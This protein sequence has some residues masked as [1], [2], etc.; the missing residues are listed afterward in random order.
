VAIYVPP[1]TKR[2]RLVLLVAAGLV[3]GLLVGFVLGRSTSSGLDDA[4][5]EVRGHATDAAVVLQRMTNG[6][7]QAG[8]GDGGDST[9]AL[10]EAI[11]RA[12]ADLDEAWDGAAWFGPTARKPVDAA[13]DE[14]D[15]DVEAE[16]SPDDF[17]AAVGRAVD[18][19]E[20]TFDVTVEGAG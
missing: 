10:T 15:R 8:S 7:V 1:S 9:R 4:L 20:T 12:R 14:L 3:V 13:L 5:D 17:E 11:D 16:V 19:I 2:R 18:A 6:Y